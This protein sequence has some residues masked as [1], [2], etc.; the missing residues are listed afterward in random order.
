MKP[1]M[2]KLLTAAGTFTG[3]L[4]LSVAIAGGMVLG[5]LL[6]SGSVELPPDI[7]GE[8][9]PTRA[10]HVGLGLLPIIALLILALIIL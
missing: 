5:N 2:C 7:A 1:S 8:A 6:S 3:V 10:L 9:G 4:L